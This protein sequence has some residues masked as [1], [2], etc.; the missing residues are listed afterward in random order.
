MNPQDQSQP[1][2]SQPMQTQGIPAEQIIGAAD[3]VAAQHAAQPQKSLE[4]RFEDDLVMHVTQDIVDDMRFLEMYEQLSENQAKIPSFLKFIL[5]DEK[6]ESIHKYYQAKG[7]KFTITKMME[8][9][10]KLDHDLNS[11]PDF[12]K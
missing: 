6:Y 1:M 5:G 2:Q 3:T 11:N 12:L 7:G 8:V 9:F 4:L 10:T